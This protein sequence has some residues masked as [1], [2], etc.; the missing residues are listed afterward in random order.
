MYKVLLSQLESSTVQSVLIIKN[1]Q[2]FGW[3]STEIIED[4]LGWSKPS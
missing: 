2:W 1:Y 3:V 4:A